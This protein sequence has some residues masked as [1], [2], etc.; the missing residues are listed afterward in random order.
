M[1]YESEKGEMSV[2][3]VHV[4]QIDKFDLSAIDER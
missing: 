3:F 1:G 2:W 4:L